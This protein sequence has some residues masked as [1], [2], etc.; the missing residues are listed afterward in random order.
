MAIRE[1]QT[2]KTYALHELSTLAGKP[3]ISNIAADL[4]TFIGQ[5]PLLLSVLNN[6]A[7]FFFIIDFSKMD[8]VYV[9]DSITNVMGYTAEEWKKEGMQAAFRTLHPDDHE[10]LKKVH[11]D[12]FTFHFS[13]PIAERK[14]YRYSTDFR[15]YRKDKSVIWIMTQDSFI[16]LDDDGK[17]SL[18]FEICT[19]VTHLKKNNTMTLSVTKCDKKGSFITEKK[20]YYPLE[21]KGGTFSTRE[22]EILQLLHLGLS[23]KQIGANL[24]ISE[25][26]VFK[27]RR[28]MIEKAGVANM[29][30]LV[31][32]AVK[33]GLI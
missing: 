26:T 19:D 5:N 20:Y 27:H 12:Q 22:I 33:N 17:P 21:K 24:S 14:D 7:S 11:E 3:E 4:K 16:A 9:S 8:Y 25:L 15:V 31:N 13:K 32:H 30:A 28:N 29:H 23:S 2:H 18:A 10:R 6:A 1:K